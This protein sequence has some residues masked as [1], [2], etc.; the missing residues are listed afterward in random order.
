[1]R[2][3]CFKMFTFKAWFW[4]KILY[5]CEGNRESYSCLYLAQR[6]TRNMNSDNEPFEGHKSGSLTFCSWIWVGNIFPMSQC[7]SSQNLV[8]GKKFVGG[9]LFTSLDCFEIVL[10]SDLRSPF[11]K[12]LFN[13]KEFF[14]AALLF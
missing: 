9:K 1:M 13:G 8:L 5:F 14:D 10:K 12:L 3:Y 7:Q 4:T 2:L 11:Q 6:V